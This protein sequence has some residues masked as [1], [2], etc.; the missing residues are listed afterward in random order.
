M[1]QPNKI[2]L[3]ILQYYQLTQYN[4][5]KR[6]M[7]QPYIIAIDGSIGVGKSTAITAMQSIL[8]NIPGIVFLMEPVTDWN[9]LIDSHGKTLLERYY[10]DPSAHVFALQT[11]VFVSM[12]S[13]LANAIRDNP[14]CTMIVQERS[15]Q[16]SIYVFA[17]MMMD[18][19]VF[20]PDQYAIY[21]NICQQC[22]NATPIA[23]HIDE[24][25]Y[26][27]AS[28]Q[29]CFERISTRA[30]QGEARITYGYLCNC[31]IAYTN[32]L[33]HPNAPM[34]YMID[35]ERSAYKVHEQ[36]ARML[37]NSIVKCWNGTINKR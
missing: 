6:D 35:A 13:Q 36:L 34:P 19:G 2:K 4:R 16:A 5:K 27:H 31:E 14:H 8:A 21:L 20:L 37:Y 30:R 9:T 11:L 24:I 25:I 18:T 29:S 23:S 32:W 22:M 15:A 12:H 26:L 33:S 17:K 1:I 7:S 3:I 28:A 10:A